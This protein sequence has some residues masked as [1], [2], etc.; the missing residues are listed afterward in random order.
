MEPR[1]D[2][3]PK[4]LE[5]SAQSQPRRFHIVRLEERIAPRKGGAKTHKCATAITCALP[6]CGWTATYPETCAWQ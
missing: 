2:T 3:P 4:A 5:P 1:R 6:E